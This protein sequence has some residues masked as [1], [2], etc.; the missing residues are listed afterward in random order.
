MEIDGLNIKILKRAIASG[1]MPTVKRWFDSGS[2]CITPWETDYSSL[3]GAMQTG[4]LLGSNEN[5]PAYRWWSREQGRMVMVGNPKDALVTEQ[6]LGT[7]KGLL[8]DGGS[9]RGNMFSG[10]AT[11]SMFTYSTLL[12]RQRYQHRLRPG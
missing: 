5:I 3:T 6:R 1:H 10:D 11:E 4:I 2:H 9:S 12:R 8:S 7:G